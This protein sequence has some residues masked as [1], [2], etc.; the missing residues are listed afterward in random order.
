LSQY[1]SQVYFSFIF[2]VTTAKDI[3]RLIDGYLKQ[4]VAKTVAKIIMPEITKGSKESFLSNI[5]SI[6]LVVRQPVG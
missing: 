3:F 1:F 2:S 4:P 6:L 5:Q